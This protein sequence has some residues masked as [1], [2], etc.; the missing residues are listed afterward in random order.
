MR[1]SVRRM[2]HTFVHN[3][4]AWV[5]SV[6]LPMPASPRNNSM[7]DFVAFTGTNEVSFMTTS[8]IW[9]SS[10]QRLALLGSSEDICI[11]QTPGVC[12]VLIAEWGGGYAV[13]AE[14]QSWAR[15]KLLQGVGWGGGHGG[16][17]PTS[18]LPCPPCTE[19]GFGAGV[20]QLP[21]RGGGGGGPQHI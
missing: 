1:G 19:G 12:N 16:P 9:M 6:L 10:P 2:G 3:L 15:R 4:E 11:E 8:S 18:P 20:P 5:R 13:Q 14:S 17:F 7:R 21:S